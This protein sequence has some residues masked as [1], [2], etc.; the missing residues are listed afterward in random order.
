MSCSRSV[1]SSS[2][3]PLRGKLPA[4]VNKAS[5]QRSTNVRVAAG[6]VGPQVELAGAD[7]SDAESSGV[8]T[9]LSVAG[10]SL[11][12]SRRGARIG[13]TDRC[14][15]PEVSRKQPAEIVGTP[16][17]LE[18]LFDAALDAIV[19]MNAAGQITHWNQ[20]A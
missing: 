7:V 14:G 8:C 5:P 9:K 15:G 10:L 6:S 12:C 4:Q 3:A 20:S 13:Q 18:L 11:I 2:W 19:G 17:G 1:I 16:S